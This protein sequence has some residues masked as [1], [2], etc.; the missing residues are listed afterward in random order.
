MD[1]LHVPSS[2][3]RARILELLREHGEVTVAEISAGL[4]V[5]GMTARRDLEELDRTGQLRRTHGG[6]VLRPVLEPA[7]ASMRPPLRVA[8]AIVALIPSGATAFL[9]ASPAGYGVAHALHSSSR[10]LTVLTNSLAV[11]RLLASSSSVRLVG[12]PGR[13]SWPGRAFVGADTDTMARNHFVDVAV[14]GVDEGEPDPLDACV[15]A[16]VVEHASETI[17]IGGSLASCLAPVPVPAVACP[18]RVVA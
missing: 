10:S 1:T 18:V 17:V 4:A 11:M 7:D 12:M 13:L 2:H 16:L 8:S 3:R 6:A 14:L 5:S 15:K 9:D